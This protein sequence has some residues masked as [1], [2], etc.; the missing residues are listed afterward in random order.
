V[1]DGEMLTLPRVAADKSLNVS[2]MRAQGRVAGAIW[3]IGAPTDPIRKT[4]AMQGPIDDAFIESF[5]IVKPTGKPLNDAV[6]KFVESETARA[7]K[8]WHGIFRGEARVKNDTDV[9]D[10]D[11]AAHNL[12]LFGDPSSNAIY[13]RIADKMPIQW[14]ADGITVG[15][16]K[17]AGDAHIAVMIQPNPL[18]P[19]H[20]VVINS[21]FTFH[22]HSNNARQTA[23]LPDWAIANIN[24]RGNAEQPLGVKA[25]GFFDEAWKLK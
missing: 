9:T 20:Y 24:E 4:H 18:N 21:G 1:I 22:D 11:I 23:K 19:K 14:T 3:Q 17:F 16:Q 25:A 13:K 8:Q 6:G 15:A 2:L 7:I 10:A 12:V 5:M